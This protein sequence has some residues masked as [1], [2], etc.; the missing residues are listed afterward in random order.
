MRFTE[1]VLSFG[2]GE[3]LHGILTEPDA[4]HRVE[5]APAV[6]SWNVG[7]HHHVGPHRFFVD[8]ARALAEAGFTSLRF[9]VSGLGDSEVSRD[10]ARADPERAVADVQAAM[11]AL[12]SQR[13]FDRFVPIGFC[14][15]VDAAH[16]VGVADSQVAGVVYLEGYGYRTRGFY[17]RYPKRFVDRNRWERLL[18]TRYP[19]LLGG[20][21]RATGVVEER[22]RVFVRDYPT[23]EKL[24]TDVRSMLARGT[25]LLLVYVGG[26]TDYAYRDQFFEM[27]WAGPSERLDVSFYPKAD[28]TFFLES[29]RQV[30]IE[31]VTRWMT[32]T[33][34]VP[35]VPSRQP[36]ELNGS[37]RGAER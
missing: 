33:F 1:K 4:A 22:E 9:D 7:L 16:A 11:L 2:T 20:R 32:A 15:G 18:R 19:G 31:R 6:L 10:D 13:G 26:D 30:V 27:I 14:S 29:D 37:P 8:Q 17:A 21:D 12:R 28:H 5:A 25:R 35:R 36:S 23:R 24:A 34:G 3:S